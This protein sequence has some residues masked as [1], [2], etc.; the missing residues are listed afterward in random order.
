MGEEKSKDDGIPFGTIHQAASRGR[1]ETIKVLLESG[2]DPDEVDERG[3]GPLHFAAD[4]GH[5]NIARLLLEKGATPGL[6]NGSCMTPLDYAVSGGNLEIVRLLLECDALL[7][8]RFTGKSTHPLLVATTRED[9]PMIRLLLSAKVRTTVSDIHGQTPVHL[10]VKQGNLE[11][12]KLLEHDAQHPPSGLSRIF[13][14]KSAAS[15]KDSSDHIP[16]F[17]AVES[18][19]CPMVELLLS[20]SAASPKACDWHKKRIFRQAVKS[21]NLEV[22]EIFLKSGAP[23]NMKGQDSTSGL[24]IAAYEG[25]VKMTRLLLEWGA[26]I[27]QKNGGLSTPE[28]ISRNAEVSMILKNH[29]KKPGDLKATK[30]KSKTSTKGVPVP[31]PEYSALPPSMTTGSKN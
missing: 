20:T 11:I 18:G 23:V 29:N 10:A 2:A 15:R 19:N 4:K 31:P 16:L 6:I 27:T 30:Q 9:I 5:W 14:G 7:A 24:H 1:H 28:Q 25:D 3:W 22:V 21:G 17:Y 13:A 12:C 26:S 8:D